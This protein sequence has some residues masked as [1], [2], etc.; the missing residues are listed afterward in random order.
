MSETHLPIAEILQSPIDFGGIERLAYYGLKRCDVR[1]G[2]NGKPYAALV[3]ADRTGEIPAKV[4]SNGALASEL[5]SEVAPGMTVKVRFMVETFE[6]KPVLI[7]SR[8]RK[9]GPDEFDP[10]DIVPATEKDTTAMFNTVKGIADSIRNPHLQ[11]LVAYLYATEGCEGRLLSAAASVDFGYAYRGGL[12]EMIH[13]ALRF[14]QVVPTLGWDVDYDLVLTGVL[15]AGLGRM[16]AIESGLVVTSTDEGD[17]LGHV[18]LTLEEVTQAILALSDFPDDLAIKVKHIVASQ[19]GR[20]EWG[21]PRA[22]QLPEA[23]I[24]H[25]LLSL[26]AAANKLSHRAR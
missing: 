4:W 2:S 7:V 20:L 15:L 1:P 24:V 3:L 14:A 26:T 22:P 25:H 9:A 5:V 11:A 6:G 21:S 13:D 16:R 17:L 18:V 8:I 23:A 12:L 19:N 10:A